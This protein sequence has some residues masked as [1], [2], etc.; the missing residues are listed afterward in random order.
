MWI[1][2]FSEKDPPSVSWNKYKKK[3][4]VH[5]RGKLWRCT[6]HMQMNSFK[7]PEISVS[8]KMLLFFSVFDLASV[9]YDNF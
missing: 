1:R 3:E 9:L 8:P 5:K 2:L 7:Y 4:I 6:P